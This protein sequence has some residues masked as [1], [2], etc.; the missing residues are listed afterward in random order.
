[1]FAD[2]KRMQMGRVYAFASNRVS[3]S[4]EAEV[5]RDSGKPMFS[6]PLRVTKTNSI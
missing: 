3:R 4:R 1:M 2:C 6:V 5:D